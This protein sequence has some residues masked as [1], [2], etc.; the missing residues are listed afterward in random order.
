MKKMLSTIICVV[1]LVSSLPIM[2]RAETNGEYGNLVYV[3]HDD[4]VEITGYID[5]PINLEIPTEI[6]NLPVTTIGESAFG[7]CDSLTNIIIPD[8]VTEIKDEAFYNCVNLTSISLPNS[9]NSIGWGAFEY[10]GFY[11][12]LSNW[13]ND[14]LYIDNYLVAVNIDIAGDYSITDDTR[15]IA[16]CSFANCNNLINLVIPNSV[17]N[18][19]TGTFQQCS[20]LASVILPNNLT[21]IG[22]MAFVS[23]ESLTDIIIPDSVIQINESAFS[24]CYS[25]TEINI[26]SG[27]KYVGEYA[28]SSCESLTKVNIPQSVENIGSGAFSHCP[29]I[30]E[31]YVDEDNNYY[32]SENG[33]LF[34]KDKTTLIAYPAD[35]LQNEYIIPESITVIGHD[36]FSSCINLSAIKIPNGVTRIESGAFMSCSNLKEIIIP[37]GISSINYMTFAGCSNLINVTIPA[38]VVSFGNDVF[39]NCDSL[40]NIYV[41]ENSWCYSSVDGVLFSKDKTELIAYPAG[42]SQYEYTVPDNV[43]SIYTSA[44]RYC[45]NLTNVIISNTVKEIG[46]NA[47]EYCDNLTNVVIGDDVTE[48]GERA[49]EGC[50]KLTDIY[51]NE[52]NPN[53]ISV[54]GVLFDKDMTELIVYPAGKSKTKYNVPEGVIN[55]HERSFMHCKQLV[56]IFIPTTVT[57]IGFSPFHDCKNLTDIY[58]GGTEEQWKGIKKTDIGVKDVP[59]H[60]NSD[61]LTIPAI[62]ALTVTKQGN[63]YIFNISVEDIPYNCEILAVLY[64]NN[65]GI[66]GIGNSEIDFGDTEK[67]ITISADS[68]TTAKAFIWESLESMKPLCEAKTKE[69]Q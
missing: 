25:L 22:T 7:S 42:K 56:E 15:C 61:R 24:D 13:Q 39:N 8:S 52:N 32:M 54:D 30:T 35:N 64:D 63:D 5:E 69:I 57:N 67:T 40:T 55:I 20:N 28:F 19:G 31:F 44:F 4:C 45:N 51:V 58:Y 43:T 41:D 1:M 38:S 12:D 37:D 68:A 34:N 26:P 65:E 66:T 16:D 14:V 6:D 33:V 47:F 59:I 62:E 3:A 17:V 27:V 48:I 49:F 36:A 11:Y 53:Y 29:S 21:Y 60:Y 50:V 23:C 10:S 18:I 9:I 46:Y 2:A